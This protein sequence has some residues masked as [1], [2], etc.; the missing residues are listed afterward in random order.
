[1]KTKTLHEQ[2]EQNA[3]NKKKTL[4]LHNLDSSFALV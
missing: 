4:Y 1:V 2:Y 3:V